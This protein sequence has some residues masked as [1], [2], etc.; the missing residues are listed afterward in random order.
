M[1]LVFPLDVLPRLSFC[2]HYYEKVERLPV[3]VVSNP[4]L[5]CTHITR[6]D[7]EINCNLKTE[8][9]HGSNIHRS[10]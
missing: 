8:K 1:C 10:K 7:V 9:K 4:G 6:V 5:H 2:E 3:A